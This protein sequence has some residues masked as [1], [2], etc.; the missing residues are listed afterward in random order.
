MEGGISWA[1]L[2]ADE[3]RAIAIL[4]AGLSIEL[5]DPVALLTLRRLGLIVGSH[6]TIAAHDLRRD[7]VLDELGARDCVM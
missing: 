6:L 2:D 7:V 3:Q 1:D 4:G 5:C